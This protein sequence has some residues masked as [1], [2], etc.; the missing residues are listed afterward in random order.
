MERT[1]KN[2]SLPDSKNKP[3]Y[4]G[5][6]GLLKIPTAYAAVNDSAPT[7]YDGVFPELFYGFYSGSYGIDIGLIFRNQQWQVFAQSPNALDGT[8]YAQ[9]TLLSALAPDNVV[10]IKSYLGTTNK[11]HLDIIKGGTTVKNFVVTLKSAAYTAFKAGSYINREMNVVTNR[12]GKYLFTGAYFINAHWY[13]CTLTTTSYSYIKW[14]NTFGDV[15]INKD[16]DGE[17]WDRSLISHSASME[18]GFI[19][20]I[21]SIDFRKYKTT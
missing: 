13:N 9:E 8:T 3:I 17:I 15:I 16:Q 7:T 14:D 11:L 20:D 21:A 18:N 10:E 1:T 4:I 5:V 19:K 2:T 12:T 6:N